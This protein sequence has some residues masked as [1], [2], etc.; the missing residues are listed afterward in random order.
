MSGVANI[1]FWTSLAG[2]CGLS[3]FE[4]YKLRKLGR[5]FLW[6]AVLATCGPIYFYIFQNSLNTIVSKGEQPSHQCSW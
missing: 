2:L 5:R 6:L 4:Y 3:F 1:V